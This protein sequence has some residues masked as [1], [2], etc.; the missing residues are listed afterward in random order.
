LEG[1]NDIYCVL[2]F[3]PAGIILGIA[4][5]RRTQSNAMV[6]LSLALYSVVPALLLES[7]LARVSGRPFSI[8]NFLFSV[9]LVIA[10]FLWIRSDE[11]SPLAARLRQEA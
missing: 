1:Y 8:S 10:G 7:I 2:V 6:I 9:L 11:E 5:G 3:F 4:A